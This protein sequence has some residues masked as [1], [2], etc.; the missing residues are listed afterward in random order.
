MLEMLQNI[1]MNECVVDGL[2]SVML[3]L[4]IVY[5]PSVETAN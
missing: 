1:Q 2:L 5:H 4:R 3:K